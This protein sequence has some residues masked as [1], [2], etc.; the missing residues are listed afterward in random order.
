MNHYRRFL[1]LFAILLLAGC[2]TAAPATPSQSSAASQRVAALTPTAGGFGSNFS[3]RPFNAFLEVIDNRGVARPYL[4]EA[5]PT[6]NSDTWQVYP[7]GRMQTRY[8]RYQLK[9]NLTWH[10]WT[11]LTADDFVFAWRVAITPGLGFING[12]IAPLSLMDEV[13]ASDART[14]IIEW[15]SLFPEAAVLQQGGSILGLPP[16]PRHILD[17]VYAQGNPDAFGSHAYWTTGFI[18]AGP[19]RLDRWEFGSF[20]EGSAFDGHTLGRPR[21]DR[22]RVVFTEDSNVALAS[23]RA[24]TL[25]LSTDSAIDFPQ[26]L[27]LKREWAQTNTGVVLHVSRSFRSVVFQFRPEYV[28]PRAL[29]DPRVRRALAHSIDKQALNE[30]LF[31]G[32]GRTTDTIFDADL[33]YFPTIERAISKYPYDLRATD[34]LMTEA[35]F[36]KGGDG[37]YTGTEGR[38]VGD[39][40]SGAGAEGD[41]E[42][43]IL[44]STWRQAGF[45]ITETALSPAQ[46]RD[47]EARAVFPGMYGQ[48]TGAGE[49]NQ[50]ASFTTSQIAAPATRWTGQNRQGWS[51][52]E[53]DRLVETF[54][55]TLEPDRRIQLRV[56]M[57][58]LLSEELPSAMLHYNLNPI[59]HAAALT[60]VGRVSTLTTGG[61]SW[62]MQEWELR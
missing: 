39:I 61:V 24:G 52:D 20:L 59:V 49:T 35:G 43:A 33:D 56:R 14:L 2:A 41:Q 55:T 47:G 9:P 44:G 23:L 32:E 54:N 30:T 50:L 5:L 48:A 27:E 12:T 3:Y 38:F 6:L 19:Y 8:Q 29:L 53:L 31:G 26:A 51:N 13:R 60:G 45:S 58:Q 22:L 10:D 57:A 17:T 21:I 34:R 28:S 11:P 42:R 37:M 16:L 46:S 40:R 62:N 15:R 18:G 36:T 25:D 4:A 1:L 7:D